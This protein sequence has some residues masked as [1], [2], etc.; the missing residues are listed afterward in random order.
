MILLEWFS[1]VMIIK[2]TYY[3]SSFLPCQI[4]AVKEYTS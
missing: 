1:E 3:F 4:L 2:T